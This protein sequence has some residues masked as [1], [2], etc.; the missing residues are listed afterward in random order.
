MPVSPPVAPILARI[1]SISARFDVAAP[2]PAVTAAPAGAEFSTLLSDTIGSDASSSIDGT[3][4]PESP[5]VAPLSTEAQMALHRAGLCTCDRN[6]ALEAAAGAGGGVGDP[7]VN[8]GTVAASAGVNSVSVN[9]TSVM[10]LSTRPGWSGAAPYEAAFTAAGA[11]HGVDPRLLASVARA[12]SNFRPTAKSPAG[13]T[14]LMQ[15]MPAT[16][17]S[18][19]IDPLDPNQAIDGA[20]RYLRQQ[21]DKFGSV[22]LALA[23]Y[24]A[25]PGAVSRFGGIPPYS[26]TRNYVTK[27]LGSLRDLA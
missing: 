25:G 12:E 9:S 4:Q 16:A 22:D 3:A 23:A 26:E 1:Q 2:R 18:M 11:K 13:A 17:R 20:A 8:L 24:N 15:F 5:G 14:G 6:A 19:G 7:A 21:M 27:V 10:G